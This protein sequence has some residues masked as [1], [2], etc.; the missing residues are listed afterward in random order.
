MSK[1]MTGLM[2]ALLLAAACAAGAHDEH[3]GNKDFGSRVQRLLESRTD[4]WFGFRRALAASAPA[5]TGDYRT[6]TQKASDQVLLSRGLKARYLTRDAGHAPDMMAF[7]P[8]SL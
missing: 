2:G 5:T 8:A 4:K 6:P 1:T 3:D 7:F